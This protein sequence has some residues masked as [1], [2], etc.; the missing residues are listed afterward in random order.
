MSSSSSRLL[1]FQLYLICQWIFLSSTIILFNKWIISTKKFHYPLT[2]VLLHMSFVS[3]CAQLWRRAGWAEA[4]TISW[5][6]TITRF[7]PIAALFAASLGFGN[8]AYLYISVAFVQMLKAATPV[9]VLLASFGFGLEEPSWRLVA[10]IVVIAIGVAVACYGQLQLNWTGVALQLAAVVVEALRLCLVNIALTSR[11]IKLSSVTF[12]SLVAPLCFLLLLPVRYVGFS[13]RSPCVQTQAPHE[14]T[15]T[16][17][18][19]RRPSRAYTRTRAC[20]ARMR[21]S[22]DRVRHPSAAGMG[23]L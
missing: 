2:L 4:P 5:R 10:Y 19:N 8:A 23:V 11:G 16:H 7:A 20:N 3:A 18:H 12:L 1:L 9:A 17:K 6:D 22:A 13:N 21:S 15:H 14:D